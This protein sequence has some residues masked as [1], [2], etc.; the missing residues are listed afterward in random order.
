MHISILNL[1]LFEDRVFAPSAFTPNNDGINDVFSFDFEA[2]GD[3]RLRVFDRWGE[4][5]FDSDVHGDHWN[6]SYRDGTHFCR[7][8]IY[9]YDLVCRCQFELVEKRGF[10]QLIR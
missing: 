7:P 8:G 5:V 3:C 2:L 10:V 6:G 1:S 9:A 4:Q